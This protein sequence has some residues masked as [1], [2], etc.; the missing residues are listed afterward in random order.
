MYV[1][2]YVCNVCVYVFVQACMYNGETVLLWWSVLKPPFSLCVIIVAITVFLRD[3][4]LYAII[5]MTV[6]VLYC[7]C[8]RHSRGIHL[9]VKLYFR[10]Y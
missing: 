4:G 2:V 1:C 9:L 10:T 8:S 6:C 7:G 5:F 3:S